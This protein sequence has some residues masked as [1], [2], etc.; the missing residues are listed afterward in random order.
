MD[1]VGL[2][3]ACDT[4]IRACKCGARYMAGLRNL[5]NSQLVTADGQYVCTGCWNYTLMIASGH[6]E[7]C[8]I[9]GGDGECTCYEIQEARNLVR[10]LAPDLLPH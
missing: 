2:Y 8:D 3:L 10:L 6:C 9:T 1:T 5:E 7:P 4:D